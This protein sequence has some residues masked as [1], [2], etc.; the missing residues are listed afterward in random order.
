MVSRVPPN[1]TIGH[2]PALL[3]PFD[4]VAMNALETRCR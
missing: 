3:H 2:P 1:K 4:G